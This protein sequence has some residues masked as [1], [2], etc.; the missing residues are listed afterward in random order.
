MLTADLVRA[1]VVKGEVKPRWVD[2]K[3]PELLGLAE[4][5]VGL[6]AQH[7]GKTRGALDDALTTLLGEGRTTSCTAGSRSS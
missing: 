6:F 7:V 3:D 2:A 4:E 5:M 1:R